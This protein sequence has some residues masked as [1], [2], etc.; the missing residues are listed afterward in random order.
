MRDEVRYL[1]KVACFSKVG[2]KNDVDAYR[3]NLVGIVIPIIKGHDHIFFNFP[4]YS[5]WRDKGL[6]YEKR[7]GKISS[8]FV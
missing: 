5:F 2:K 1:K 3:K 8:P 4:K 6:I 7:F